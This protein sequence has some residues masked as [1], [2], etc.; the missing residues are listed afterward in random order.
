MARTRVAAAA[1]GRREAEARAT[2]E[3]LVRAGMELFAERGYAEVGTEE[4][5]ARARVTRGALYHHFRDKRDLF[6]AVHERLEGELVE[7]VAARI[8]GITDPW[9]LLV[10][11]ARAF[12][13]ECEER[14]VKRIALTDAPAVLGWEEWREVDARYGLGLA[15][16]ALGGAIEAGVLRQVPLEPTSHLLIAALAE[17]AFLVA[18]ADDPAAARKQVDVALLELLEGLRT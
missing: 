4:I 1:P 7:R 8:E 10:A 12:L 14:A 13:D 9:D 6:R 5:V 15:R 3:T 11:G 18:N 17:A 16:A 2:R